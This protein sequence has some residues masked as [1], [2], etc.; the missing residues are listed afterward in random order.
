VTA[1]VHLTTFN[2][3]EYQ[4]KSRT[5]PLQQLLERDLLYHYQVVDYSKQVSAKKIGSHHQN[6]NLNFTTRKFNSPQIAPL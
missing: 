4:H 5:Y 1:S 2:F 3:E 6:L